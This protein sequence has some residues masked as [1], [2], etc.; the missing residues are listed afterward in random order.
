MV[1]RA[2]TFNRAYIL[3]HI[4]LRNP[5]PSFLPLSGSDPEIPKSAKLEFQGLTPVLR[6]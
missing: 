5:A 3:D 1:A 6:F 4:A 2:C